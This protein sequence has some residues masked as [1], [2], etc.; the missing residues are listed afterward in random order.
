MHVEIF[1]P[2][3]IHEFVKMRETTFEDKKNKEIDKM[4]LEME[5]KS[6]KRS[7]ALRLLIGEYASAIKIIWNL[8]Y[9]VQP[10]L[11]QSVLERV[12][13][14][15]TKR[16]LSRDIVEAPYYHYEYAN[17]LRGVLSGEGLL[18]QLARAQI[19]KSE[20]KDGST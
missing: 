20:D 5:E 13:D 14:N 15:E 9:Y 8:I 6:N 4:K 10:D 2:D 17:A 18:S 7:N 16:N 1:Q 19:E 11:R 3:K 12:P